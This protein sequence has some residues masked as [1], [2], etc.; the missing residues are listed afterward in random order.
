MDPSHERAL[1]EQ[2]ARE[3]MATERIRARIIAVVFSI[4]F[5]VAS[6]VFLLV[7]RRVN[8]PA[9]SPLLFIGPSLRAIIGV[10]TL[11]CWISYLHISR[12][13]KSGKPLP[14]LYVLAN[15]VVEVSSV[16]ALLWI[17][18]HFSSVEFAVSAP[19]I[20]IY[21]GLI[22]LSIL[23]LSSA[24]SMFVAGLCAAQYLLFGVWSLTH[25]R[26]IPD[27]IFSSPVPVA[28]RTSI[29]L[30]CGLGAAMI[31]RDLRARLLRTAEAVLERDRTVAMFGQ[32]VSPQVA[33][34]LLT[35]H[36]GQVTETRQVCILFFDIRDFTRF[37]EGKT[38]SE[39]VRFLNT[40]FGPLVEIVDAHGGII[41]KFLGDGFLAIF[42]APITDDKHCLSATKAALALVSKVA[43]LGDSGV[44]PPTR[45]GIGLHA[46]PV[47]TGSV[48]SHARREY[49]VIGDTVN[50][51]ARVEQQTKTLHAQVL[52]TE[53]VI[54][55]LPSGEFSVEKLDPVLVKGRVES[56]Q[57]YKLA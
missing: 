41:N 5:I 28:L 7:S 43:A 25:L 32:H 11:Y 31:S 10:F 26:S 6:T 16:T 15:T 42:G 20:L 46:G 45:I 49:T 9:D 8:G 18:G 22:M 50:L 56:V 36:A 53:A 51:A 14:Y 19:P 12:K 57:L 47:V 29:M 33:E 1:A 24:Y 34:R 44:I 35:T 39:V 17:V 4:G 54:S 38:P 27:S 48:G 2:L 37:S 3:I 40:L 23:R 55:A 52:A 13:L 30:V 21:L